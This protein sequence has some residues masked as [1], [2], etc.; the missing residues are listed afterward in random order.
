[1]RVRVARMLAI[2]PI[3]GIWGSKVP[4][5]GDSLPWTLMQNFTPLDLSLAEKYVTVQTNKTNTL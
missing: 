2:R 5:M 4:Q 1:M 3:L